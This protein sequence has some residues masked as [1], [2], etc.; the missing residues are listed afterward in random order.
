MSG[1]KARLQA[2]LDSLSARSVG[3][4]DFEIDDDAHNL[5]ITH[6]DE[7]IAAVVEEAC[8]LA[9]HRNAD[10]VESIDIHRIFQKKFGLVIPS[11]KL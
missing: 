5:L 2:L 3:D 8:A 10:A 9:E 11:G 7:V 6:I 1:S 4:M